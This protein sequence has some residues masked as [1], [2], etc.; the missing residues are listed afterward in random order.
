VIFHEFIEDFTTDVLGPA[1]ENL[2]LIPIDDR[3]IELLEDSSFATV[4][5]ELSNI[6]LIN[7]TIDTSYP[8]L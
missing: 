6:G 3:P 7:G 2:G 4:S 8:I 5:G 1:I